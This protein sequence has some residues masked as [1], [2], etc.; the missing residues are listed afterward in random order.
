MVYWSLNLYNWTTIQALW[1]TFEPLV[2]LFGLPKSFKGCWVRRLDCYRLT[3]NICGDVLFISSSC[4]SM[5]ASATQTF[6]Y[7][8]HSCSLLPA[9]FIW[10]LRIIRITW[11]Q[12]RILPSYEVSI[13][14]PHHRHQYIGSRWSHH[15]IGSTFWAIHAKVLLFCEPFKHFC[16]PL[17]VCLW[18]LLIEMYVRADVRTKTRRH[19]ISLFSTFT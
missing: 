11:P 18:F 13:L 10:I 2:D 15:Q 17:I 6:F 9:P 19:G 7:L 3:S 16:S 8:W 14:T 5:Y 12:T 1:G 4:N